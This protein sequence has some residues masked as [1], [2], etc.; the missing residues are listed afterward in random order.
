MPKIEMFV[1]LKDLSFLKYT[2]LKEPASTT[3]SYT[4][5]S[6]TNIIILHVNR[7]SSHT[8]LDDS[9]VLPAAVGRGNPPALQVIEKDASASRTAHALCVMLQTNTFHRYLSIAL[10]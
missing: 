10:P 5:A 4:Q 2:V 1:L 6:A 7:I 9:Q 3:S 8:I